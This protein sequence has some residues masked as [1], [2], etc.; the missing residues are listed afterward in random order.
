MVV[1]WLKF[2]V[3]PESRERFVQK[4]AEI[5]TQALSQYSGF[6]G[7]EVWISPDNLAE[8]VQVIYWETFDQWYAIPSEDLERIEA[9]FSEA[10]G[11]TYQLTESSRYQI[12]RFYRPS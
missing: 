4:D 9:E 1:E 12:R 10:M 2:Q 6:I 3:S 5:W 7:K 11:D 8:V